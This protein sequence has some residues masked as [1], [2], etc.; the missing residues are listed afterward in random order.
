[1]RTELDP[2]FSEETAQPIDWSVADKVLTE[3][4]TS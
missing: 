3:A 1:M 2:E 4:E